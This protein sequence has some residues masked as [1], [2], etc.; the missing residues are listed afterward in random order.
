MRVPLKSP[1]QAMAADS[2]NKP[3]LERLDE[4]PPPEREP[5]LDFSK[6]AALEAKY[7]RASPE[8]KERLSKVIERGP[9]GALVKEATGHR[10]QVREALGRD[11]IA[12]LKPSGE[13]Y[14]EAH[15]VSPVS[16]REIGSLPLT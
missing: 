7:L 8:V 9:V 15:H 10:C 5:G 3:L 14:V 16:R 6:L 12:F 11:P 1:V 4:L 13:L 2:R